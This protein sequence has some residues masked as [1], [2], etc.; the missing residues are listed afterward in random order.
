MGEGKALVEEFSS[1][2][3]D[4]LQARRRLIGGLGQED[5]YNQ[6]CLLCEYC[7][8]CPQGVDIPA[9]FELYNNGLI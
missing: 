3:A 7:L 6:A 8:P 2:S 4:E 5:L 9:M 1:L